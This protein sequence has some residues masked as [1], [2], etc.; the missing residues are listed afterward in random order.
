MAP[1]P[2][3]KVAPKRI[4]GVSSPRKARTAKSTQSKRLRLDKRFVTPQKTT[5]PVFGL[6]TPKKPTP[7]PK[8][9]SLPSKKSDRSA[10]TKSTKTQSEKHKRK[11]PV[12][13]RSKAISK[14]PQRP[15][16]KQILLDDLF[17]T[18]QSSKRKLYAEKS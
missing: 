8:K 6:T 18:T 3:K 13:P 4:T 15:R 14:W 9:K 1:N 11:V 17:R 10:D 5:K 7:T 2:I 12:N 16:T